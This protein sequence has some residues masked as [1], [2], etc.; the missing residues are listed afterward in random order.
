MIRNITMSAEEKLIEMARQKAQSEHKS[1][2]LVFREWLARYTRWPGDENR[3][4][5]TMKKLGYVDP[6]RRF[7][8]DDLNER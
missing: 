3:L 7:S 1:F 8:R 5:R 2:N 6:G 4:N